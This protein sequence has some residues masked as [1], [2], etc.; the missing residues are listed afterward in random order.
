MW[1][2]KVKRFGS[3]FPGPTLPLGGAL[4]KHLATKTRRFRVKQFFETRKG[5]NQH[6]DPKGSNNFSAQL[7]SRA[8]NHFIM[9]TLVSIINNFLRPFGKKQ[10]YLIKRP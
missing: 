2:R 6:F 9:E 4:E 1:F 5:L 8:E 3:I 10:T 7:I